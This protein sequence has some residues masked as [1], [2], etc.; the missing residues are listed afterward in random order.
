MG[1]TPGD[2]YDDFD[3]YEDGDNYEYVEDGYTMAV[4]LLLS[5]G[6]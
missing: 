2:E 4:S 1:D 6:L 3:W 5:F